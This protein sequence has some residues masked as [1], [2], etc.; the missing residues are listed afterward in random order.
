MF[1]RQT[2][3]NDKS[4]VLRFPGVLAGLGRSGDLVGFTDPGHTVDG[5]KDSPQEGFWP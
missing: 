5:K 4:N 3:G 1:V 2:N